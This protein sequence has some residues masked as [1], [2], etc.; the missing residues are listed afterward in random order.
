M[1]KILAYILEEQSELSSSINDLQHYELFNLNFLSGS[2]QNLTL[3]SIWGELANIVKFA[4]ENNEEYVILARDLGVFN[5]IENIDLLLEIVVEA[6]DFNTRMLLAN[7]S[8]SDATLIPVTSNLFWTDSVTG[9]EIIVIC[10][11][12]FDL[13]INADLSSY[14][15]FEEGLE[16]ITSNKMLIYPMINGNSKSVYQDIQIRMDRLNRMRIYLKNNKI[17]LQSK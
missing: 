7:I 14:C 4:K 11:S 12:C 1:G 8:A 16:E 13:I 15:T 3:E 6:T 10:G 5:T 17:K 2:L 9:F